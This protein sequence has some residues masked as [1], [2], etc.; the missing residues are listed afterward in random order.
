M[1]GAVGKLN[2]QRGAEA[3]GEA[4]GQR[5]AGHEDGAVIRWGSRSI[6]DLPNGGDGRWD[7]RG[8]GD[9][10]SEARPN[11]AVRAYGLGLNLEEWGQL[12]GLV[13]ES[14]APVV[15]TRKG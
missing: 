12:D 6:Q 5:C 8:V 9:V 3:H 10:D 13:R 15:P 11:R 14:V 2:G 4:V 1:P 7:I